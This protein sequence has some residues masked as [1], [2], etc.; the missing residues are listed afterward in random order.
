MHHDKTTWK[1]SGWAV[2]ILFIFLITPLHSQDQTVGLF[3]KKVGSFDG[4]TV[5]CPMSSTT[6]YL[7][8]NYG[9]IVHTWESSYRPNLSVYLLEN[10]SMMRS[11]KLTD[12]AGVEV[13]AWDGTVEWFYDFS[14]VNH[15]QHHDIEPLPNGNI[16]ILAREFKTDLEAIDAGRDPSTLSDGELFS[17]FIVEVEPTGPTSG[18]VVWAWHFW[19]HLVQD[20]DSSKSNYSNVANHSELLDINFAG[21]TRADWIHAN[22]IEYNPDLDQIIIS[23][24]P[25][26]EVWIIDHGTTTAEAAGHSGGP[27]GKGG[28]FLYRW[29]NPRSYRAGT[30][31]DQVF[32][33]QHDAQWIKPG[34][35]GEGNILVFNNGAGR[36]EGVF[37]TIEEIVTPVDVAGDYPPITPGTPHGPASQFWTYTA[38]PPESFYSGAISGAQR[39]PNGN[40]LICAG[41]SGR[42]F[43][44]TSDGDIVWEYINP[45]TDDGIAAQGEPVNAGSNSV[46]RISRYGKDFS[47]FSGRDLTPEGHIEIYPVSI[48]GTGHGPSTPVSGDPIVITSTITDLSGIADA[49]LYIDE[50]DGFYPF[51]MFDDGNHSDALPGDNIFGAVFNPQS[52]GHSISYYI[53]AIDG[54]AETT[55]DPPNAPDILYN[56]QVSGPQYTCG[57]VNDDSDINIGDAIYLVN[58]IF[59][60]GAEPNP[61][62]SGDANC[63]GNVNIADVV[64]LINYIFNGGSAPCC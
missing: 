18:T 2:F 12:G 11:V 20:F 41:R 64:Y 38:D 14:S 21:Q 63:D 58:Y 25:L 44:V 36:P 22:A 19:D 16:L 60:S 42:Y 8:D 28:D 47:G 5:S 31:D 59:R 3:T 27:R 15:L 33:A 45:A 53:T 62:E 43:E 17:E 26:A 39:L 34:L 32:Y 35:P 61:I 51:E 52:G 1:R 46:F 23:G 10:G 37:S 24:R 50:G 49:T 9:R 6:T 4:Y 57:N 56:L 48:S 29:G 13:I 7:I 54:D 30:T 40:T 55:N